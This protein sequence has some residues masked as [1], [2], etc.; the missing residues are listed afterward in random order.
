M[1]LNIPDNTSSEIEIPSVPAFFVS[2][3]Y[4][5]AFCVIGFCMTVLRKIHI[6]RA[7]SIIIHIL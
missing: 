6:C 5:I 1:S 2:F 7:C 3:Y 4:C